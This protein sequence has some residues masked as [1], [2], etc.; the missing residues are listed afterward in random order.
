MKFNS[1]LIREKFVILENENDK[2]SVVATSNRM[3]I[4]FDS[5]ITD[6]QETFIVR[7][8]NMHSCIRL[9]ALIVKE[10]QD[11]GAITT[12]IRPFKW[13]HIWNDVIKGYEKDWNPDIWGA[14]YFKGRAVF[15]DGDHHPFLD[16]IEKCDFV[17][18]GEYADSIQLAEDAF[19]QAGK[20]VKIEYDSNVALIVSNEKEEAKCGIILRSASKTTTFN[21][22]AKPVRMNGT[23]KLPQTLSIS[24]AFLEGI[25]LAFQVGLYNKK[26][27]FELIEK[28]SDEDKKGQ[29]QTERLAALNRAI[30]SYEDANYVMFRPDRPS[31]PEMVAEAETSAREILAPQIEA[32]IA[33]GQLEDKDWIT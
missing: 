4:S 6:E 7:A 12:R 19:Q 13:E 11:R 5:E 16:I 14:V 27:T 22:T 17:E 33:D 24:A 21:F 18:T 10:R 15:S 28:Y 23:V 30:S 32:M 26:M 3:V 29:R 20:D 31:F 1:S 25:Q 8:Q 2:E 9:A